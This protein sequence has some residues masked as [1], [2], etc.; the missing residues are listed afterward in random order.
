MKSPK[1]LKLLA[2]KEDIFKSFKIEFSGDKNIEGQEC[3][4]T[5]TIA[6]TER[7]LSANIRIG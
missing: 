5:P 3:S 4:L 6:I 2:A 7:F 1:S